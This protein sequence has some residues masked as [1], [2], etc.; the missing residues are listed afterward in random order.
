MLPKYLKKLLQIPT[1]SILFLLFFVKGAYALTYDSIS[2]SPSSGTIGTESTAIQL[3]VDSGTDDFAGYDLTLSFTGTIDYIS[4]TPGD[5]CDS[6]DIIENVDSIR[7]SCLSFLGD[8]YNGSTFTLYFKATDNG[9]STFSIINVDSSVTITS[10]TGGT[11]TL[12]TGTTDDPTDPPSETLP[13]SGIFD[14]YPT[15]T[16][17]IILIFLG[18][19]FLLTKPNL[20]RKWKGTVVIY[21]D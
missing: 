17:G 5:V 16:I 6:I 20:F 12:S 9:S 19:I 10:L 8:T 13:A 21:D 3:M 4:A 2:L 14:E 1:I 18:G 11:Y 15:I 7:I